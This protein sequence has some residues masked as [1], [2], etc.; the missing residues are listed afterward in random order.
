MASVAAFG[1]GDLS[2]NAGW[3][4]VSNSNLK[5]IFTSNT[6][7]YTLASTVTMQWRAPCRYKILKWQILM[8]SSHHQ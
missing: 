7:M 2:S 6:N 1:P 8:T 4:T 5:L 3:Y